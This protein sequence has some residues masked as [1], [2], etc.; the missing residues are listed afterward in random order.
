MSKLEHIRAHVKLALQ[1]GILDIV[2]V[3]RL[4]M[5]IPQIALA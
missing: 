3:K 1:L 4:M 5:V 2:Y